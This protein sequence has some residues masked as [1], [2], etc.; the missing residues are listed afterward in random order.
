MSAQTPT[1]YSLIN[2]WFIDE[3]SIK[4]LSGGAIKT[5]G[6]SSNVISQI[7]YNSGGTHLLHTDIGKVITGTTTSDTA[8]ILFFDDRTVDGDQGKL[9]L[10]PTAA[11]TDLFDNGTEAYTVASSSAVGVFTAVSVSGENTWANMYTIGTIEFNTAIYVTKMAS[12]LT[13]WASRTH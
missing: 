3:V 12:K 5:I 8:T 6:W 7:G 4:Y 10:R 2:G 1:E 9:W 13:A 11:A